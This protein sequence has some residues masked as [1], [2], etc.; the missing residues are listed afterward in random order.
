MNSAK[1][2][3]ERLV[4]QIDADC[5][6][7]TYSGSLALCEASGMQ[8]GKK[9]GGGMGEHFI[10]E[11]DFDNGDRV[12]F[13]FKWYDPSQAFSSRPDLHRFQVAYKSNTGASLSHSN[14]Y[15]Q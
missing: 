15:E 12:A 3:Y 11:L 13:D 4:R 10:Y 6:A 7:K 5:A 14:D 2:L 9:S 1:T 8:G